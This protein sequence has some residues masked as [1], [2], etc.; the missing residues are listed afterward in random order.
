MNTYSRRF[1]LRLTSDIPLYCRVLFFLS[2]RSSSS[3]SVADTAVGMSR[4]KTSG[5]GLLS[6]GKKWGEKGQLL[7]LSLRVKFRFVSEAFDRAKIS[8]FVK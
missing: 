8:L 4:Q 2:S 1:F 7:T 5:Q 6:H 3:S